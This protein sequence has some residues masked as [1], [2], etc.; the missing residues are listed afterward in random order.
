M[1]IDHAVSVIFRC[2][3]SLTT[4]HVWW[5]IRMAAA[6][7]IAVTDALTQWPDDKLTWS[8]HLVRLHIH[9]PTD[10][11]KSARGDGRD[12]EGRRADPE[13]QRAPRRRTS[14]VSG[15]LRFNRDTSFVALDLRH[16]MPLSVFTA[17]LRRAATVAGYPIAR[18]G[19]CRFPPELG[20]WR[21]VFWMSSAGAVPSAG[22]ARGT[23]A[24]SVRHVKGWP[25]FRADTS[26]FLRERRSGGLW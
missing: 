15:A 24:R 2:R 13:P 11:G 25:R 19:V 5:A 8:T 17:G 4:W 20:Q 21:T 26:R 18:T 22:F 3:E 9:T 14:E 23:R 7:F 6:E 12:G 1:F 16:V 10:G